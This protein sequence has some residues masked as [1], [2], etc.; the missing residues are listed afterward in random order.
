MRYQPFYLEVLE[1]TTPTT[2]ETCG[3]KHLT[4]LQ[5]GKIP[6]FY[7]QPTTGIDFIL[8]SGVGFFLADKDGND[9]QILGEVFTAIGATSTYGEFIFQPCVDDFAFPPGVYRIKVKVPTATGDFLLSDT[10][11]FV[12]ESELACYTKVEYWNDCSYYAPYERAP[13]LKYE[14]WLNESSWEPD[15]LTNE[16]EFEELIDKSE[17]SIEKVFERFDVLRIF[18]LST[19][20]YESLV[21]GLSMNY[22]NIIDPNGSVNSE[23]EIIEKQIEQ[24]QYNNEGCCIFTL[25]LRT[26]RERFINDDCCDGKL[27]DCIEYD[28]LKIK[29]IQDPSQFT[30]PGVNP[31][32]L[33]LFGCYLSFNF[34][35]VYCT[36]ALGEGFPVYPTHIYNMD[37]DT[38]YFLN[39]NTNMYE[40]IQSVGAP[41]YTFPFDIDFDVKTFKYNRVKI[42][43]NYNGGAFTPFSDEI[44]LAEKGDAVN[45]VVTATPNGDEIVGVLNRVQVK[46]E[47]CSEGCTPIERIIQ[48]DFNINAAG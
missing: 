44:S 38:Y 43:Y 28:F 39:P 7:F 8:N 2:L 12:D 37:T 11:K 47:F 3:E 45:Y 9:I 13:E 29:S 17:L 1:S 41:N 27:V 20:T 42:S 30:T 25:E 46:V 48:V 35:V 18:N 23:L 16:E 6:A 5:A 24:P 31:S 26:K 19:R 22:F 36:D 40:Q 10:Y 15:E 21:E 34:D 4:I 32:T 33:G 14:F